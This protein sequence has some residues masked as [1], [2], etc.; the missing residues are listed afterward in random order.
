MT[1]LLLLL[2]LAAREVPPVPQP[3]PLQAPV[4]EVSVLSDGTEVWLLHRPAVPLVRVEVSWRQGYLAQ[5]DREAAMVAGALAGRR[6]GIDWEALEAMGGV[7]QLGAGA[8][9]AWADVEVLKGHE[10]EAIAWLA[11]AM[12]A[13]FG[14]TEVRRLSRRWAAARRETWRS[15]GRVHN[16]VLS[17]ELHPDEHPLGFRPTAA[18]WRQVTP[19]RVRRAWQHMLRSGDVAVFVA[20][21]VSAEAVVAPLEATLEALGAEGEGTPLSIPP[22][23]WPAKRRVVVVDHPG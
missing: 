7:A 6:D 3:T 2:L 23:D 13:P 8:Q 12:Q 16:L 11:A 9:R 5:P 14:G 1:G 10:E 17:E 20:G 15:L 19:R 18:D 21:D 4:P 22:P